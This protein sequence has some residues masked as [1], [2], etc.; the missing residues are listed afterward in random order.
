MSGK[1]PKNWATLSKEK[2]LEFLNSIDIVL[3]D[4]DGEFG[5]LAD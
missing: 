4:C 5:A 3:T 2:R 1:F